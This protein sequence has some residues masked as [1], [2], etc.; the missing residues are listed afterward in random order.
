MEPTYRWIVGEHE[1]LTS[2][3]NTITLIR[4]ALGSLERAVEVR[5]ALS[6]E[7]RDALRSGR[8]ALQRRLAYAHLTVLERSEA[9][10]AVR[11]F[12]RS[13]GFPDA[14]MAVTWLASLAPKPVLRSVRALKRRIS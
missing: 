4:N 8:C 7:E 9:R 1:S 13:G 14:L 3:H 2:S 6:D 11:A 5:G 12:A 10:A